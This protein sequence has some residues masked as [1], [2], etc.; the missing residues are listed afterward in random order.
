[1]VNFR[2]IRSKKAL[3]MSFSFIFAMIVG[4]VIIFLAIYFA[5]SLIK[6]SERQH[7]SEIAKEISILINPLQTSIESSK[8]MSIELPQKTKIYDSCYIETPFGRQTFASAVESLGGKYGKKGAEISIYN[9]YI[10]SNSIEEG[11]KLYLFSKGLNL[12]FKLG[13]I[14]IMTSGKYCFVAPPENI[15][16]EILD[17]K[18]KGGMKNIEV[19]NSLEE[20]PTDSTSVCFDSACDISVYKASCIDCENE[21]DIGYVYKNNS[22]SYYVKDLLYGAIFSDKEVY[23]CNVKRLMQRA[24]QLSLLFVD[25]SDVMAREGCFTNIDADLAIFASAAIHLNDS[26]D[27]LNI[28]ELAEGRDGLQSKNS[29][30][31]CKL[32]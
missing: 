20:C 31:L 9:K 6:T 30:S 23:D 5:S 29:N 14:I 11:K 13:D 17:I 15:A 3:E 19:N 16:E 25:T 21:Y 27:L 2:G 8:E 10:F 12:P 4:A 22:R 32:W 1:M 26:V 28:R 18:N 24:Y 7:S